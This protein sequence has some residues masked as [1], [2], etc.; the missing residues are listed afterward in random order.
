LVSY[1]LPMVCQALARRGQHY[2]RADLG[3][4]CAR[5]KP[6]RLGDQELRNSDSQQGEG[7]AKLKDF[8]RS[9]ELFAN[10]P[11]ASSHTVYHSD[12]SCPTQRA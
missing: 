5:E 7:N 3:R 4:V 6:D 10:S 12:I 8:E 1:H 2:P 11:V 9:P